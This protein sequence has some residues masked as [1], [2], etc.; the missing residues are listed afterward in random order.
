M[1]HLLKLVVMAVAGVWGALRAAELGV[2]AWIRRATR[3]RDLT[4]VAWA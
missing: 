1:L 3:P 2:G 4:D